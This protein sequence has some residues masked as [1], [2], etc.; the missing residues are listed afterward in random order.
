MALL[1]RRR[2]ICSVTL[3]SGFGLM[4][5][6]LAVAVAPGQ[7]QV[8]PPVQSQGQGQSQEEKNAA[9]APVKPGSSATISP[10]SLGELARQQ[11]SERARN[12]SPAPQVFTNDN[13]PRAS[14]GLSIIGPPAE[15]TAS[16]STE[17]ETPSPARLRARVADLQ[18]QLDVHRRELE[19]LQQKLGESEVQYY[20][21]P[22]DTLRQQYSRENID[23]LTEAIDQKRKQI[24]ANQQALSEAQDELA[25]RGLAP[26]APEVGQEPSPSKPDL[27]GLKKNSEEYWRRRFKAAH[28]ALAKAQEQQKLAED[29]LSLLES[30]QAHEVASGGAVAFESQISA[31]QAEL[32]SKK[33]EVEQAQR[34]LD[35]LGQE[36]KESG[37][38]QGWS[39]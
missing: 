24:E 28:E 12:S 11:R 32:E 18:Q 10:P 16:H 6:V 7:E 39:E 37:S 20:P 3:L 35:A 21:N 31:K 5:A 9:E 30:Q 23:R 34:D 33:A 15:K 27:T 8:R 26:T 25:A 1:E 38:P 19:V 2:I 36:F 4:S 22:N 13:L 29:E 17:E 14:G